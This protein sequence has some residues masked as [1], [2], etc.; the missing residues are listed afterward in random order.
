MAIVKCP[1]CHRRFAGVAES[2]DH[3]QDAH[4]EGELA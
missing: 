3:I 2:R 4:P 1:Y